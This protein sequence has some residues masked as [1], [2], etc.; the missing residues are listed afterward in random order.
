MKIIWHILLA[1]MMCLMSLTSAAQDTQEVEGKSDVKVD[2]IRGVSFSKYRTYAWGTSHQKT[3]DPIWNQHLVE[4]IDGALQAKG[5]RKVETSGSPDL[6]VA[7][8]AG[9]QLA[10][11]IS[12]LTVV[13]KVKE[14]TLM[15]EL[16]DPQL[17]KTV[18]WGIAD[19]T[20]TDKPEKDLPMVRKRIS[21]MFKRYPP[22][23]E[24]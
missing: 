4:D 9:T 20:L 21:K 10:Y 6:I 1:G 5:L 23:T 12:D 7:Y 16:V 22:P 13:S 15:V 11:S 3:P 17:G 14:G 8:A 24:K 2:W 18:W 19:D